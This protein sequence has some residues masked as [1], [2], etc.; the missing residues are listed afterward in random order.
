MNQPPPPSHATDRPRRPAL[1]FMWEQ[2]AP[3]HIDRL[4][5]IARA[6]GDRFTIVGIE[7]SASSSTYAWKPTPSG[8]AFERHTLFTGVQVESIPWRQKL[9]RSLAVINR[10]QARAVFLCNQDQTE[11]LSALVLLRVRGV[12]TYA[13]LD[14]KFDDRPRHVL[15]ESLK[16]LVLRLFSGG[17]AGGE[18]HVAYYRFLGLP[19]RWIAPGYSAVSA[20]RVRAEA[21]TDLAPAGLD[22]AER[23]FVLVARFVAKK[24]IATAIRAYARFRAARPG[25]TR[26]LVLCGSG[27]TEPALRALA[28]QSAVADGVVFAGF[29]DAA[30]VSRIVARALALI[31]PS[32]QEPWG[33]VVNE[34]VSLNIPVLCTENVGARDALVRTGVNGFIV[35]AGND[36]GLARFMGMLADDPALWRDM[37]LAC[38]RFA[39][40]SDVPAF[41]AG[42]GQLL[43]EMPAR[44]DRAA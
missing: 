30:A 15:Q 27:A 42:I 41:A 5:A 22:H 21:E 3:Y 18:R 44:V 17:I 7:V 29:L 8:T 24:D 1:I 14:A 34:A 25:S 40:L 37:S 28:D 12:P 31:L 9:R 6:F 32:V 2:F 36:E 20:A 39:P 33:L 19:E 35:E 26:R 16:P 38:A 10:Y 23:D 11:I 4:E 13:L 43:G